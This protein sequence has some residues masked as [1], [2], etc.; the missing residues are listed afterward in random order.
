MNR[1]LFV[2]SGLMVVLTAFSA[3]STVQAALVENYSYIVVEDII[4]G[5]ADGSIVIEDAVML[6]SDGVLI[7]ID[8]I[9]LRGMYGTF[10]DNGHTFD[11]IVIED[12]MIMRID[13]GSTIIVEDAVLQ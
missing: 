8:D 10:V 6:R 13:H 11:Y 7:V 2:L 9:I 1:L 3:T 4:M 12:D 5:R